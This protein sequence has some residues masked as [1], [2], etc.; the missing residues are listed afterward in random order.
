MNTIN[1]SKMCF[2]MLFFFVKISNQ[3]VFIIIKA[4]K[5]ATEAAFVYNFISLLIT[6]V[7]HQQDV[8]VLA[9]ELCVTISIF[10]FLDR[11]PSL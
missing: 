2:I 4:L 3:C 7:A 6:L 8:L 10:S 1:T 9:K 5:K 11:D